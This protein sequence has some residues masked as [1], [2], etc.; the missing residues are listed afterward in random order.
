MKVFVLIYIFLGVMSIVG[1]IL[2]IGKER[3]PVTAVN[4]AWNTVLNLP[5]LYFLIWL[6]LNY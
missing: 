3:G 4:A 2:L 5:L 6:F 1:C